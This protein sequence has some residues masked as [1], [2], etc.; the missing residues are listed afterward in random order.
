MEDITRKY[1]SDK[2]S[3]T[4]TLQGLA[5]GIQCIG[6]E[7]PFLFFS[8]WMIKRIGHMYCMALGLFA[9]ALRFYL[10][11]MITNPIWIL[12]VEFING[13]TFG[14]CHAVLVAY[15]RFIA[16]KNSAT[17]VV[18]FTGAL[19]E[20]V[21]KHNN[22]FHSSLSHIKCTYTRNVMMC[23]Q[24]V[25]II[26]NE[27]V[28]LIIQMK[29]LIKFCIPMLKTKIYMYIIPIFYQYKYSLTFFTLIKTGVG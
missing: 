29:Q 26:T 6:G 8:G 18:A 14:L 5:I 24:Y 28:I 9:F 25:Y 10:Y 19:F 11:S 12:P 27:H 16:P 3:W 15:A 17:T 23:L 1:H 20:G 4:K 13:M 7:M 22:V 21:G 2:Q